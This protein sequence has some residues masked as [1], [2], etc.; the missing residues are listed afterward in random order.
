ML[1]P[2]T[3][4]KAWCDR[5]PVTAANIERSIWGPFP[6]DS[7]R[8]RLDVCDRVD[9]DVSSPDDELRPVRC[10]MNSGDDARRRV[11]VVAVLLGDR[12]RRGARGELQPRRVGVRPE[13]ER[14]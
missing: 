5:R 2:T 10:H 4:M 8:L 14:D 7:F 3:S 11:A 13:R 1:L 12:D 9:A 6:R